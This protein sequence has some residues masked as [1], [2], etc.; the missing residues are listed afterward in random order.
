MACVFVWSPPSRAK[1]GDPGQAPY[2]G[3]TLGRSSGSEGRKGRPRRSLRRCLFSASASP[4]PPGALAWTLHH[5]VSHPETRGLACRATG[6]T[7]CEVWRGP[8]HPSDIPRRCRD[9]GQVHAVS[10]RPGEGAPGAPR[11]HPHRH[12]LGHV[13][14]SPEA[15]PLGTKSRISFPSRLPKQGGEDSGQVRENLRGEG[16]DRCVYR[17]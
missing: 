12:P 16:V 9:T 13:L 6:H 8:G 2:G 4:G 1:Q 17:C 7:G 15:M 5:R 11:T 14:S 10:R 3:G